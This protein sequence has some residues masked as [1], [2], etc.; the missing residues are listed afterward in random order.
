MV[1][2][3]LNNLACLARFFCRDFRVNRLKRIFCRF[4]VVLLL[5]FLFQ[6]TRVICGK[7]L[8]KKKKTNDQRPNLTFARDF[9]LCY[10]QSSANACL[11][12]YSPYSCNIQAR[13]RWTPTGPMDHKK[14]LVV[15][16][17]NFSWL[18]HSFL[19]LNKKRELQAWKFLIFPSQTQRWVGKM[20]DGLWCRKA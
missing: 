17:A 9:P 19:L 3:F 15:E 1:A 10:S 11:F 18:F 13:G 2:W 5:D 16:K 8:A 4:P 6:S 20:M 7:K 14:F 12:V